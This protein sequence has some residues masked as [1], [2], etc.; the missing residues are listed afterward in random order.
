LQTGELLR[1]RINRD[2]QLYHP[3]DPNNPNDVYNNDICGLALCPDPND[4]HCPG[5][6]GHFGRVGRLVGATYGSFPAFQAALVHTEMRAE[7]TEL[8]FHPWDVAAYEEY[9]GQAIPEE[10]YRCVQGYRTGSGVEYDLLPCDPN[11]PPHFPSD[12]VIVTRTVTRTIRR[13]TIRSTTASSS[14]GI[15]VT[16]GIN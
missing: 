8:C 7:K 11:L 14:S 3:F 10:M 12:R 4:P 9:S 15:R 6:D 2:L 1:L 13:T 16:A 5:L